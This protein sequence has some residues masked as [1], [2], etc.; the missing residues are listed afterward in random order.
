[1]TTHTL[2]N[3]LKAALNGAEVVTPGSSNYAQSIARWSD[4]AVKQA[5]ASPAF[6]RKHIHH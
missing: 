4:T 1:M 2:A 6:A 3:E 5:V